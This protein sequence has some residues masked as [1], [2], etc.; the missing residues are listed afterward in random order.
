M[1]KFKVG[2]KVILKKDSEYYGG[3][4]QLPEGIVGT[5]IKVFT[6]EGCDTIE[7]EWQDSTGTKS[8]SYYAWDLDMYAED[9]V[10]T[11]EY[12]GKSVNYYKVEITNPTTAQ[13]KYVAEC[14]DIIEALKM[15][16]AEGNAFKAIWRRCAARNLGKTKKGYGSGLYDAEKGV[17]FAERILIQAKSEEDLDDNQNCY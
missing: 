2:D 12:T 14:N 1:S 9:V 16:Y 3:L 4:H 10:T 6:E 7:V 15:N 11:E 13:E 17:F 8:N 5:V